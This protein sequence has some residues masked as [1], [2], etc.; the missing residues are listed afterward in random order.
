VKEIPNVLHILTS[1]KNLF[2][3][4]KFNRVGGEIILKH[5]KCDLKNRIRK[6]I[7]ICTLDPKLSKLGKTYYDKLKIIVVPITISTNKTELW[8][9]QI[10]HMGVVTLTCTQVVV[11]NVWFCVFN[12][13]EKNKKFQMDFFSHNVI[14]NVCI[15]IF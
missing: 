4:K 8:H 7:I 9:Q 5:G 12:I 13:L 15:Y 14:F 6:I 2:S 10:G 11:T 1:K 3:T